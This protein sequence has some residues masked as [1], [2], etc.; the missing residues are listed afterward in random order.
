MYPQIGQK[1]KNASTVFANVA[2]CLILPYTR[3]LVGG[4][5]TESWILGQYPISA[6]H[7]RTRLGCISPRFPQQLE[8]I[9]SD[10]RGVN[11]VFAKMLR[12]LLCHLRFSFF[13]N[14]SQHWKLMVRSSSDSDAVFPRVMQWKIPQC[15]VISPGLIF[16]ATSFGPLSFKDSRFA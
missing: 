8:F 16:K 15:A 10:G 11:Q 7:G 5:E 14:F 3:H 1:R 13:L 9:H 12:L 6:F 4:F 2:F